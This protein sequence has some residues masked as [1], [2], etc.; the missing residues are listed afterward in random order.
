M[1]PL[2]NKAQ[3]QVGM[4][5][6]REHKPTINFIKSYAKEHKKIPP[7]NE[8]YKHIAENHLD[9]FPNY[10]KQLPKFE[11]QLKSMQP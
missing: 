10:Y 5:I 2:Y 1:K 11:K 6:E 7:N 3:L 4:K 9:E 8:I